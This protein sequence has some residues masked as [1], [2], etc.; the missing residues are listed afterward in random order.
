MR[1]LICLIGLFR[2]LL[3]V[4]TPIRWNQSVAEFAKKRALHQLETCKVNHDGLANTGYG[5][6][7]FG[8]WGGDGGHAYTPAEIA[9]FAADWGTNE[10]YRTP[11]SLSSANHASQMAWSGSTSVGCAAASNMG[12]EGKPHDYHFYLMCNYFPPGNMGGVTYLGS[13]TLDPNDPINAAAKGLYFIKDMSELTN[14]NL[15]PNAPSSSP[16]LSLP[17]KWRLKFEVEMD[18]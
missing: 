5:E 3:G 15:W 6:N 9:K 2:M 18:N 14:R 12:C 17:S 4:K 16:G 1:S 7:G 10:R 8:S 11:L 13:K